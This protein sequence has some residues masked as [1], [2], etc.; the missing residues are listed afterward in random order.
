MTGHRLNF[1]LMS[2]R[3]WWAPL[4]AA[5]FLI[6][7]GLPSMAQD[8]TLLEVLERLERMDAALRDVQREIFRSTPAGRLRV[9]P[10]DRAAPTA[11]A[12]VELRIVELEATI[13]AMTGPIEEIG[14]RVDLFEQ[15]LEKL[16]ADVDFRLTEIEI[17]I[18]ELGGN[19]A[20]L[21]EAQQAAAQAPPPA[22]EPAPQ[23]QTAARAA[24]AAVETVVQEPI[25]PEGTPQVQYAYARSLLTRLDYQK[26]EEAFTEFLAL[27]GEHELAGNAQYWL[28]ETYY[29][30][31]KYAEAA[32]AFVAGFQQFPTGIK[33]PDNLLKLGMSLAQLGQREDACA[34]LRELLIRFTD[35]ED[36]ITRRAEQEQARI[37]C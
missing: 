9:L 3:R 36:R 17:G 16:V 15:R 25:L 28:G 2:P 23:V 14:H 19:I 24:E 27:N 29:V 5:M 20:T 30:R 32:T 21:I 6:G 12:G 4:I 37:G 11:A 18:A 10:A 13:A 26:A 7:A 8:R 31:Q 33:A 34:T 35:A 22:Q 1:A